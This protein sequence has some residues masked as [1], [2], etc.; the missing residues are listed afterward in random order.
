MI[1]EE[2][3]RALATKYQTTELNIRREYLQHVFLSH[4]YSQP[5][6]GNVYFKGG[7]ALRIVFKSPRFSEDLDFSTAI[8]KNKI[9]DILLATL[10]QIE[11]QNI[12]A[13]VVEAKVTSGGYLA[14][15]TYRAFAKPITVSLQI[16]LREG[17]K[18]GELT[19]IVNDFTLP[20][21]VVTLNQNQLVAEKIQA[22]LNRQKPRDFYDLYFILRANMLG[23][24]ERKLLKPVLV[25]LEKTDINFE[26]ELKEFLPKSQW[27]IIR[28]FKNI[29]AREVKRFS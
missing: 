17:E 14:T 29:L 1:T 24:G 5:Q 23:V 19:T 18:I 20:Y 27:P 22:L 16:S 7:T 4:F 6:A 12:A 15:I 21:T 10:R 25:L 9:E 11:K 3:I 26:L 2:Q 8:S 13:Q 28:D